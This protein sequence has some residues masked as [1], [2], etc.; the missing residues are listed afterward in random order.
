MKKGGPF[1]SALLHYKFYFLNS[2]SSVLSAG[3]DFK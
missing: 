1:R 3:L 2:G